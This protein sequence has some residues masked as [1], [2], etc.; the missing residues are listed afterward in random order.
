MKPLRLLLASTALVVACANAPVVSPQL[1]PDLQQSE[2]AVSTRAGTYRFRVWIAAD[3]ESREKGL[4]RVRELPSDRGM[5]FLFDRPQP[6]AFWMK[7]TYLSLDL[8]FIGPDGDVVNVAGHARPL[9]LDPIESDGAVIAVLEVLAGTAEKI[10][11]QSGD[12]IALPTL[13]TTFKPSEPAPGR[14]GSRPSN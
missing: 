14:P 5:L 7:D 4:M 13:R 9:S 12:R 1:F 6:V 3:D 10:G 11:L 2:V 8:V